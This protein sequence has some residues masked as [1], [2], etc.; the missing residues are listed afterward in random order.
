M[1]TKKQVS[2]TKWNEIYTIVL[3]KE[4]LTHDG[5]QI[6]RLLSKKI[7]NLNHETGSIGSARP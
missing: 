7:N 2:F 1:K 4:H 5:L 6:I 3:F